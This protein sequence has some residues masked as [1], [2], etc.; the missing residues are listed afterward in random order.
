MQINAKKVDSANAVVDA[1]VSTS[2]LGKKE[3]KM[4]AKAAKSM[5]VDGFRKGKVPV[6]VV[7]ARHSDQIKQDVEQEVLK[8]LFDEAL[9]QLDT[10]SDAVV[11]EPQISKF[12]RTDDG[13]EV[14][15]KISFKPTID[16]TGYKDL[17][18]EYKTPRIMK[19]DIEVRIKDM[20]KSVAS[21]KKIEEKRAVKVGDFALID[22]DGYIDGESFPGGK[23]EKYLLEVGSNSFIPGFEDQ[24]VGLGI[25]ENKEIKVAFPKEYNNKELA[26]KDAVFKVILHGIE[27]KDVQD[28][29]DEETLKK[30]LPGVEKPTLKVLED[31]VKE[32]LKN[33]KLHTIFNE[34]VKPKYVEII[35]EKIKFDIPDNIVEQE[36]DMQ[37]RNIFS[38]LSEDKIKEYSE[39]PKK[40]EEKRAEFTDEAKNSVKLTF[41]VD[42]LAKQENIS[43][44][45]QEVTQ[46]IYFEAMQQGQDPKKYFEYYEKQ[47]LLPAIKMSVVEEKLFTKLF[48]KD[49]KEVKDK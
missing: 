7:K 22:F 43:V 15:V 36:I 10:N 13:L 3:D 12:D 31:Q 34:E 29:P 18:P 24:L 16:V 38:S 44:D 40:I 33:E 21:M 47:G 35:L 19:K 37:V 2:T 8:E 6:H 11:G 17:V 5:K 45:D 23:A 25:G 27:V 42:E 39:N 46:M 1:K 4:A 20:L 28:S 49:T 30:L 14:E 41:L 26:G 9:K 48:T 32:Q